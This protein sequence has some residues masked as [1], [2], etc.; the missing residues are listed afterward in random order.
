MLETI[1]EFAA[2]A[3]DLIGE[4]AA[5]HAAHLAFFLRLAEEAEPALRG[6]QPAPALARLDEEH[7]NLRAALDWAGAVGRL[8]EALRLAGALGYYLLVRGHFREGRQ[9]ITALLAAGRG[10]GADLRAKALFWLATLTWRGGDH[11][12]GLALLQES[13]TMYQSLGDQRGA[14]R[15]LTEIG[16]IFL[17][18]GN[19]ASGHSYLEQGLALGRE[20]GD[21][22][23][24][25][26]ALNDLG[27]LARNQGDYGAA[28]PLYE[29]SLRH[30]RQVGDKWSLFAPLLN[31]AIVANRPRTPGPAAGYLAE[32]LRLCLE[33]KDKRVASACLGVG[34]ADLAL[35]QA[36]PE[37]A[38]RL[39]GASDALLASL[40][41]PWEST[42][43]RDHRALIMTAQTQLGA[44]AYAA[45]YAAGQA[46]SLEDAV[47]YALEEGPDA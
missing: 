23:G 24:I 36:R 38:A 9:R 30:A 8:A 13:L 18:T 37:R 17:E 31:I 45:A 26:R 1:H 12:S 46:M 32:A 39:L 28:R 33:M 43:G 41:I 22:L 19:L 15:V 3:L 40:G 6:P 34:F 10:L 7:D 29:E 20:A 4:G 14:G 25:A 21:A 44:T 5:V 35:E 11:A 2:E 16:D 27:E 47:A 42:D